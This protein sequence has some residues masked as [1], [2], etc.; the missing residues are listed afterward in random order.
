MISQELDRHNKNGLKKAG[1]EAKTSHE[2]IA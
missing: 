2:T 1:I